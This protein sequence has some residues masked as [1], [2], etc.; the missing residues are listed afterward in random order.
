MPKSLF[1]GESPLRIHQTQIENIL[2]ALDLEP[3]TER[4]E[5][6]D[7]NE[8]LWSIRRGSV[9]AGISVSWSERQQEGWFCV[10]APLVRLPEQG[11][12][13]FYRRLLDLNG[14][15]AGAALHTA[16]DT[17]YLKS[18]RPLGGMDTLEAEDILERVTATAEALH[19]QLV[20]EFGVRR[21]GEPLA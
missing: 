9:Q 6:G 15:I 4:V 13:A 19:D 2:R 5:T 7:A 1:H 17:V 21:V 20:E 12:P 18:A 14:E 3:V 11:L 10:T 8:L 16:G